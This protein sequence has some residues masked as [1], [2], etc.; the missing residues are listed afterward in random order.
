[1]IWWIFVIDGKKNLRSVGRDTVH[2][3]EHHLGVLK[4]EEG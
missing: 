4:V 3:Y 2:D 1:M